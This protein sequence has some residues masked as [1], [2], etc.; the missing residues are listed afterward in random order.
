LFAEIFLFH[1]SRHARTPSTMPAPHGGSDPPPTFVSWRLSDSHRQTP[2]DVP[3]RSLC[4]RLR[5][6]RL[7]KPLLTRVSSLCRA[8][9]HTFLAFMARGYRRGTH[10]LLRKPRSTVAEHSSIRAICDHVGVARRGA[11]NTGLPAPPPPPPPACRLLSRPSPT[12]CMRRTSTVPLHRLPARAHCGT[13]L[14]V[15]HACGIVYTL[16]ASLPHAAFPPRTPPTAYQQRWRAFRLHPLTPT[17][18]QRPRML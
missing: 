7:T 9:H 5:S 15:P 13:R 16:A 4:V 14:P 18:H 2:V 11:P 17:P 10:G 8:H 12:C 1:S 3:S 6:P